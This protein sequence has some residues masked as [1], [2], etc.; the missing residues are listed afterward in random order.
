MQ[1]SDNPLNITLSVEELTKRFGKRTIFKS[2]SI[3]FDGA[4]VYGIAGSNGAGKSTLVKV[5][6]GVLEA[7]GKVTLQ[8]GNTRFLQNEIPFNTGFVAPYFILYDEFSAIENLTMS[9]GIRGV[10]FD[11]KRVYALLERLGLKGREHDLVRG[12]SSGM[13]QRLKYVNA[14]LHNAPL[15]VFDEP[16]SN[17]D[18]SGKEIVYALIKELSINSIVILASNEESDLGLCSVICSVEEYR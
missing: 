5:I 15:Y 2:L 12:Y 3:R 11:E 14:L 7:K 13:K 6:L 1:L 17:L 10:E 16:T 8:V 4:G 18:Q 9:C